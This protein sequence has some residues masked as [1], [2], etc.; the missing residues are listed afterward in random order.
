MIFNEC[1]KN[2]KLTPKPANQYEQIIQAFIRDCRPNY[3]NSYAIVDGN[4]ETKNKGNT[5]LRRHAEKLH[6]D[7]G[8]SIDN[9]L[10][11]PTIF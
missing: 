5:Q 11:N 8:Q 7:L 10:N 1:L 3:E 6:Q 4:F 2:L 9:L